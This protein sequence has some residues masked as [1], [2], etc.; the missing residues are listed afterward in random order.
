MTSS[1][2]Y[3]PNQNPPSHPPT[4]LTS[5]LL[6]IKSWFTSN[7]FKLNS[8]ETELL[9]LGTK[10]SLGKI[11][12]SFIPF[13]NS[14]IFL[15]VIMDSTLSFT[16]HLN[17]ITQTAYF[18]LWNTRLSPTPL[19]TAVLV[20]SLVTSRLDYCK[21]LLFGLTQKTHHKL[22][23]VQSFAPRIVTQCRSFHHIPPVLKQLH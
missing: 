1:Y 19:C 17:N 6:S 14:L 5:C 8:N 2:T 20:H 7:F 22:L 13:D 10:S 23:L 16:F 11:N 3:P 4:S 21:S 15:G 18:H 12:N 9:L